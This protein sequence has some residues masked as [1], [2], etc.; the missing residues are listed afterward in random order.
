MG[1]AQPVNYFTP[2]PIGDPNAPVDFLTPG[3][4]PHMGEQ[5]MSRW[6]SASSLSR[7][8]QSYMQP[9]PKQILHP[10]CN[11]DVTRWSN[12]EMILLKAVLLDVPL[13]LSGCKMYIYITLLVSVG[14][15]EIK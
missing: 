10:R 5:Q 8:V 3:G 2:Q 15:D 1:S 11:N 13:A 9:K 6:S 4:V 12:I 14:V 7:E